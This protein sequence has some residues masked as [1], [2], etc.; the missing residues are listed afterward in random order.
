MVIVHTDDTAI[1]IIILAGM[2]YEGTYF[3]PWQYIYIYIYI[4]AYIFEFD[5]LDFLALIANN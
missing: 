1:Y 3:S 2:E 4:Y 5:I